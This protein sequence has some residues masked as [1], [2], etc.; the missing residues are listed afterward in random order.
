[1]NPFK[2]LR[3]K[4]PKIIELI[5][6]IIA[7]KNK[8]MSENNRNSSPEASRRTLSPMSKSDISYGSKMQSFLKVS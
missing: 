1:M 5:L 4:S 7:E 8:K 3:R 2:D 6:K